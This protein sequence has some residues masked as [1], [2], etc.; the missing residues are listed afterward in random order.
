MI[1][2]L[3]K[4]ITRERPGWERLDQ[5]LRQLEAEPMRTLPLDQVREL[6]L[7]YQRASAD[8]ARIATFSAEPE[9]RRYLENLVSRGYA[10]IHGAMAERR[11]IRLWEWLARTLPQTFRRRLAAWRL[12]T[13]LFMA[14]ALFGGIALSLDPEAKPV[15]LPFGQLQGDPAERVSREERPQAAHRLDGEKASFA[16]LLMTHNI[17]VTFVAMALGFTWGLGTLVFMFYNGI[18]LGAVAADYVMAGQTQFL[19]GWLL[20]HGVIEIPAMLI[21]GAGR[22]RARRRHARAWAT[23]ADG[24]AV[25]LHRARPGD[26]GIGGS[27]DAGMGGH[28]GGLS[29]A[30]SRT[31][32]TVP[33]KNRIWSGRG[34]GFAVVLCTLRPGIAPGGEGS[35]V[36]YERVQLLQV[37]TPEGVAFSFRLASPVLRL[38]ALLVDF[39]AVLA[40]WSMVS[41]IIRLLG[42]VS[43]DLARAANIIGYFILSQGYRIIAEWLWRGQTLGKKMLQLRVVDERGLRLTFSQIV[44]RNLLRFV[45]TL[46]LAYAVGGVAA[47][48][49]PRGQRLGDLAAGTLVVWEPP[50]PQ[51]NFA[52][53][54]SDKYNSLRAHAAVVAR[55]RQAV[56]HAEARVA[57]Q[58]LAR[59]DKIEEQFRVALFAE[60]AAHF[61]SLTSIPAD[62]TEGFSDEQFVRNVVDVLY[63]TRD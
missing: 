29:L 27:N 45:D 35:A 10:E 8:L 24:R 40:A 14:G 52:V 19:L 30:I 63:L 33:R 48:L 54:R 34:P 25:T 13:L 56:G 20:P 57:W 6:E 47:L 58:A 59:G 28:S 41:V 15:L 39:C 16:G 55:L 9:A 32:D 37:R 12:A 17:Q 1:V 38:G 50:E 22:V 51:P 46:P 11:Q 43:P 21:G 60:L 42:L 4:F 3:E 18:I 5:M 49:S 53:F 23:P 26:T 7:L 62:A 36:S 44:L 2:N 61:K 31:S